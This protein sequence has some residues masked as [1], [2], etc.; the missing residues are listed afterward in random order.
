MG[1]VGICKERFGR[2][3]ENP[4]EFRD[5]FAMLGL[6]FSTTWQKS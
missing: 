2:F 5:E 1:D 6:T 4:D 3:S